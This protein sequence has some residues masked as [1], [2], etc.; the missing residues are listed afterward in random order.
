M[1]L[2]NPNGIISA[3][4]FDGSNK[5]HFIKRFKIETSTIDKKFLFISDHKASNLLAAS[6]NYSPNVQIKHKPDGKSNEI[7]LLP[8][9]ELVEVR[10]WKA[11]G[12]KLSY[13]KLVDVE[14]IETETQSP[15]SEIITLKEKD[16]EIEGESIIENIIEVEIETETDPMDIME[17]NS[18]DEIEDIPLTIKGEIVIK[19]T[20]DIPLEIKNYSEDSIPKEASKGE[21]LGLF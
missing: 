18:S 21:Q 8:I 9:D 10:G 14:F 20:E 1:K 3:V 4:Y 5:S 13:A 2:F 7:L 12:S 15:D 17:Q 6:D 19:E 16:L 11:I